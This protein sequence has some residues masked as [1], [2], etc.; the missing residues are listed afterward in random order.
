MVGRCPRHIRGVGAL[1]GPVVLDSGHGQP[2]QSD[3]GGVV[4][5]VLDDLAQVVV[6]RFDRDAGVDDLSQRGSNFQERDEAVPGRPPGHGRR[7][8]LP[9]CLRGL[10]RLQ[11]RQSSVLA[12]GGVDRLQALGDE[13][14]PRG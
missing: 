12:E 2:E 13:P 14:A 9:A 6:Q 1:A 10:E 3:H 11:R 4:A 5:A 8:M 7:R